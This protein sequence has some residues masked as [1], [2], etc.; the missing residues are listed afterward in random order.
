MHRNHLPALALLAL[1]TACGGGVNGA[2]RTVIQ[3]KGSDTLLNV[4][5]AWAEA[6]STVNPECTV[7]V[8]GGGSGTGISAMINGTVDLA[9][10][11]RKMKER[12]L[13]AAGENGVTPVE[14]VVGY[15]ALAVYVHAANPIESITME[16]LAGIYGDGGSLVR[17][18]QLGVT[19]PNGGSDEIVRV[20]RQNNS[21]TFVYFR[22]A[23]LGREG[24][25]K[26]GSLD[27]HGSKDVVDLVE[28][29]PG[30]IGYSGLAYATDHVKLVPVI[31]ADS[32][33]PVTPSVDT[34]V[35]RTYP[36]ARPLLMYTAGQPEGA[37]AEYLDWILSD[38]GQRIILAKGYAPV[39]A[40]D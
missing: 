2:S 26:L 38:D 10:A 25:Y 8:S 21:G 15:D 28:N 36:I 11:S 37:V 12:E 4:A 39:R 40:L 14:F 27:M 9:N 6:Y 13:A 7:A 1:A 5:Q 22:E 24:K 30:A 3:N 34:A 18:S 23:V 20:S 19:I 17:W 29:T 32:G 16:Q 33:A 31:S 35:D